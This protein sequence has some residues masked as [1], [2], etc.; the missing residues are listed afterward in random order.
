M[1]DNIL[2]LNGAFTQQE[3]SIFKAFKSDPWLIGEEFPHHILT[4]YID[5]HP[6]VVNYNRSVYTI[7]D[8]AGDV[9]GLQGICQ[10]IGQLLLWILG[11]VVPFNG[12]SRSLIER[13]FWM[14]A[15]KRPQDADKMGKFLNRKPARIKTSCAYYFCQRDKKAKKYISRG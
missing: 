7:F 9:G 12:L 10:Q 14:R 8:L 3:V 2:D 1:A 6:D 11:L 13:I 4:A 15:S 5:M